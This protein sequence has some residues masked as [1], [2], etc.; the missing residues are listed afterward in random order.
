M[1]FENQAILSSPPLHRVPDSQIVL[2][3]QQ[4]SWCLLMFR[5]CH[6]CTPSPWPLLMTNSGGGLSARRPWLPHAEVQVPQSAWWWGCWTPERWTKSVMDKV[7]QVN[8]LLTVIHGKPLITKADKVDPPAAN[9]QLTCAHW[10][11][12]SCLRVKQSWA[13]YSVLGQEPDPDPNIADD[14]GLMIK[15]FYLNILGSSI[16]SSSSQQTYISS[17]VWSQP[18]TKTTP[19]DDH[20]II[21][22]PKCPVSHRFITRLF[23]PT[24]KKR[25]TYHTTLKS[26]W[27]WYN[28]YFC[29]CYN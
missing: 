17:A 2:P 18:G 21:W 25:W 1:G 20:L 27:S 13:L 14:L 6:H 3:Y 16:N 8:F 4:M 22:A 11:I 5:I 12:Q 19:S 23:L 28:L 9:T 24:P 26:G 15:M 29:P 10:H 7:C